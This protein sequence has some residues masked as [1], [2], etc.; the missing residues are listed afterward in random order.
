M[1]FFIDMDGVLCVWKPASGEEALYEKGFFAT[2]RP[3]QCA[4]DAVSQRPHG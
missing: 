4:V 3:R 1:R 2:M